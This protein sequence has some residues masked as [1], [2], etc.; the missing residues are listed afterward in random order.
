MKRIVHILIPVVLFILA[1]FLITHN[2]HYQRNTAHV[3]SSK[4]VSVPVTDNDFYFCIAEE[5]SY[6][7]LIGNKDD[8]IDKY[9]F[10]LTPFLK[11]TDTNNG[12][13][14]LACYHK[15]QATGKQL[16]ISQPPLYLLHHALLIP[17]C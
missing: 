11:S 3:V 16:V 1:G 10:S 12:F 13:C 8:S 9:L 5:K 2:S 6:F 15:P 17:F 14:R 4:S 7:F